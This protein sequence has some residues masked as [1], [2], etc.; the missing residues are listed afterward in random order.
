MGQRSHG[1]QCVKRPR[2]HM[3]S[4]IVGLAGFADLVETM[5]M[6]CVQSQA[7]ALELHVTEHVLPICQLPRTSCVQH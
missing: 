4:V 2:R 1:G 6:T 7:R 3:S 5:H